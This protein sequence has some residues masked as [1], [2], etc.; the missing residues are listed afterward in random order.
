MPAMASSETRRQDRPRALSGPSPHW[1]S[2]STDPPNRMSQV[3]ER[4]AHNAFDLINRTQSTGD[5]GR[6]AAEAVAVAEESV[7]AS[8]VALAA[9]V[10]GGLAAAVSGS[11]ADP[12]GWAPDPASNDVPVLWA[13]WGPDRDATEAL[14]VPA[15]DVAD[16][17]LLVTGDAESDTSLVWRATD[18]ARGVPCRRVGFLASDVARSLDD[19]IRALAVRQGGVLGDNVER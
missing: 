10:V 11:A 12:G 6:G 7:G 8:V 16:T 18:L 2:P 17:V 14:L 3:V 15:L 13:T 9:P 1:R 19:N 4:S 5:G